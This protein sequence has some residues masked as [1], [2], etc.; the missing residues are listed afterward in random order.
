MA[1]TKVLLAGPVCGRLDALYARVATV[2]AASGPFDVL[3][4]VGQFLPDGAMRP[5]GEERGEREE[6]AARALKAAGGGTG[7]RGVAAVGRRRPRGRARA[8]AARGSAEGAA[9][10]KRPSSSA[11][12][13]TPVAPIAKRRRRAPASTPFLPLLHPPPPRAGPADSQ[14]IGELMEYLVGSKRAPIPTYFFDASGR[15]SELALSALGAATDRDV[16]Y[17][18][19]Q[20]AKR[21]EGLGVAWLDEAAAEGAED[22]AAGPAALAPLRA[23]LAA[24][25]GDVDLLLTSRWSPELWAERSAD[26]AAPASPSPPRTSPLTSQAALLARPRYHVFG[27]GA[28]AWTNRAPYANADAGAG[29]S[30]TRVVALAPTGN[31]DKQRWLHAL[32]LDRQGDD[33]VAGAAAAPLPAGVTASPYAA[34]ED[35][36]RGRKRADLG[37]EPAEAGGPGAEGGAD[38]RWSGQGKRARAQAADPPAPPSRGRAGVIR[39]RTKTVFLRNLS[40]FATEQDVEEMLKGAGLTLV[41]YVRGTH[42]RRA[43]GGGGGGDAVPPS[44][45]INSWALAQLGSEDE[46]RRALDLAGTE[47]RGRT[48]GVEPCRGGGAVGLPGGPLGAAEG[49]SADSAAPAPPKPSASCWFCLSNP[50]ADVGLVA[51]VGEE[52][53]VALDKGPIDET[54]HALVVPI[55]HLRST[56][57]A[58]LSTQ[59]EMTQQLRALKRAFAREGKVAVGFERHVALKRAAQAGG[60]HCHVNVLAVDAER[61][62][63]ARRVFE[64]AIQGAGFD[65]AYLPATEDGGWDGEWGAGEARPDEPGLPKSLQTLRAVVGDGE[66]FLALLPDGSRLVHPI[67]TGERHPLQLGREALAKV[68]GRPDR[69]DWRTCK[70]DEAEEARRVE[71]LKRALEA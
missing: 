33:A 60:N 11:D 67:R 52:T 31:A 35:A 25:P 3:F 10:E 24:L 62:E 64:D 9:L 46:A 70:A 27:G 19:T 12:G 4:C 50:N 20:G 57:S 15:G 54:R 29:P 44:R 58:P 61:G 43:Q 40:D 66:Y 36:P 47:L 7:S 38:W 23:A 69:A 30:A 2:S 56:V 49:A 6:R 17:L 14:D 8:C 48:L 26:A 16:T 55:E 34:L 18:G 1:S 22:G 13:R 71:S 42:Q 41:D 5:T 51:T 37:P 68:A 59:R 65:V 39:D 32:K 21:V 28:T 45:S 63:Q 53:Y